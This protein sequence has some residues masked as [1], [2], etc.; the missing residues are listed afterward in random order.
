MK[1]KNTTIAKMINST[2]VKVFLLI[3][4]VVVKE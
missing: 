2:L 1:P 3:F 4:G